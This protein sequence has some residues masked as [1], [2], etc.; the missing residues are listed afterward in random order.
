MLPLFSFV[1]PLTRCQSQRE[2]ALQALSMDSSI[3]L[4]IPGCTSDGGFNAVQCHGLSGQCWCVDVNG[5]EIPGTVV[6]A[7]K[8]DCDQAG[9]V[10]VYHCIILKLRSF[11]FLTFLFHLRQLAFLLACFSIFFRCFFYFSLS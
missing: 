4:Y 11:V 1:A 6:F 2:K 7:R 5:I 9:S 10:I 3:T 8:P